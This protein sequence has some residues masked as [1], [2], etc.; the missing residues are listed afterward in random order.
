MYPFS[1]ATRIEVK[2]NK[3]NSI[4]IFLFFI[5]IMLYMYIA[6]EKGYIPYTLRQKLNDIIAL[7]GVGFG[8]NPT[9]TL[10]QPYIF[11]CY[12]NKLGSPV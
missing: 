2:E 12:M 8:L 7:R 10:H 9:P 11:H 4:F 6:L 5:F 3:K 1:R